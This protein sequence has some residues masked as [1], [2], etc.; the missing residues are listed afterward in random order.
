MAMFGS[1]GDWVRSLPQKLHDFESPGTLAKLY[2]N[3][4]CVNT[5]YFEIS[6][7]DEEM[8]PDT[9]VRKDTEQNFELLKKTKAV[10]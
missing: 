2:S 1:A 3:E 4:C 6:N 8:S 5:T 10:N 7:T 9:S